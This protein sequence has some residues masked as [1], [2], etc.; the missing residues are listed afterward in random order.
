M[1]GQWGY[2]ISQPPYPSVTA[3]PIGES[4][5]AGVLA[6]IRAGADKVSNALSSAEGIALQSV[7]IQAEVCC[8]HDR[9]GTGSPHRVPCSRAGKVM[10]GMYVYGGWGAKSFGEFV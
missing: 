9:S 7:S 1:K 5:P 10:K 8:V 3:Y 6:R 2:F 4:H